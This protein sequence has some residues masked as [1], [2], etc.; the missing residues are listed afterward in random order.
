[1]PLYGNSSKLF[2]Q[3]RIDPAYERVIGDRKKLFI[4]P[5]QAY[6]IWQRLH[7]H[8]MIL[9]Q[10]IEQLLKHLIKEAVIFPGPLKVCHHKVNLSK[11]L[12]GQSLPL[13]KRII[14]VHKETVFIVHKL[15]RSASLKSGILLI[16]LFIAEGYHHHRM[17]DVLGYI[18]SGLEHR[19]E[20]DAYGG[21]GL[22]KTQ[23]YIR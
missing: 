20:F 4:L 3:Q 14:P 12:H 19:I 10:Y 17:A 18:F 1:M 11:L 2:I 5:N 16:K 13:S 23:Q 9:R 22:F 15:Y 8:G 7:L 6:C 21:I